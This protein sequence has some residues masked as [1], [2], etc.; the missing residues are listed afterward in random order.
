MASETGQH[1]Q[2]QVVAGAAEA[3]KEA[4]MNNPELAAEAAML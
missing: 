4:V 3:T 2:R 1:M